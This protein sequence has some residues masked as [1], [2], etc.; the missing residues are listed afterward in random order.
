MESNYLGGSCPCGNYS[1][2]IVWG[3]SQGEFHGSNCLGAV[4][5]GELSLKH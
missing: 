3:E 4:V 2:L 5:C 1:G